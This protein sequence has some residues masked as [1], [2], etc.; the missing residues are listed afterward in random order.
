M[1][2]ASSDFA[3]RFA[4]DDGADDVLCTSPKPN[5]KCEGKGRTEEESTM[6]ALT[7]NGELLSILR[8]SVHSWTSS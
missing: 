5:T 6:S 8:F 7:L 2:K 3:E 4:E 1:S